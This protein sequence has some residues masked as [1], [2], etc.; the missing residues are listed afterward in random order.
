M[1]KSWKTF[2]PAPLPSRDVELQAVIVEQ[3]AILAELQHQLDQQR[4]FNYD[5]QGYIDY[6]T[7]RYIVAQ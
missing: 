4:F 6:L 2:L 3:Q 5:R 7:D 1:T